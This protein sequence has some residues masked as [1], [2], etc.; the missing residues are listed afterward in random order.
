MYQQC[1]TLQGG[2]DIARHPGDGIQRDFVK[3]V[4]CISEQRQA[5]EEI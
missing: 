2:L 1:L 4:G 3:A 5:S